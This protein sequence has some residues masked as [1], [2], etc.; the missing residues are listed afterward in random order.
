[1]K[2]NNLVS[3][4][5]LSRIY[6]GHGNDEL[7]KELLA[8]WSRHPNGEFLA[9]IIS[10]A[11]DYRKCEVKKALEELVKTG[12]IDTNPQSGFTLYKLHQG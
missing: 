6:S 11:L 9:S 4:V 10:C 8:F 1:M 7:K 2:G 5:Q 12:L 3:E